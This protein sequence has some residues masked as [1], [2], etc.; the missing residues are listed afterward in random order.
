MTN[1]QPSVKT[2]FGSRFTR[3]ELAKGAA[4]GAAL[5]AAPHIARAQDSEVTLNFLWRSGTAYDG[6]LPV[7]AEFEAQHPGVKINIEDYPFRQMFEVVEIRMQARSPDIDIVAVDS[8]LTASYSVRG[9]LHPLNDFFTEE[10]LATSWVDAI[11]GAGT[12]NGQF[13]SAP[14]NNSSQ[15]LYL[16]LD[17]FAAQGVEP[18]PHLTYGV[19]AE[20]IEQVT[21]ARWTWDQ[22][23][24]AAQAL[25][26]D[27]D[28]DGRTDVWGFHFHQ[29]N[30]P[31][32]ILALPESLNQP[33]ISEDGLV[34]D[35]YLNSENWFR[36][37]GFYRDLFNDLAVS[38]KGVTSEESNELFASGGAAMYLGTVGQLPTFVG[39][40]GLN[41]GVAAHPYFADGRVATPTGSW[42]VGVSAFSEHKELAGEFV[43]FFTGSSEGNQLWYDNY[44]D[45]PAFQEL[46]GYI[47]TAEEFDEF[48]NNSYRLAAYESRN[49]AVPRPLTPGWLEFEDILSTTLEDIRNGD[50]PESALN[51]AVQR[52]DRSLER[53]QGV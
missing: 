13:M 51:V 45:F 5:F 40:E 20:A 9:F 16:N 2:R 39:R 6:V 32:Q 1:A 14:C 30:R 3:R 11:V 37:A 44:G 31:Y 7:V 18:P 42:H 53:F 49:T 29:V 52:I 23:A 24:E 21:G 46:L 15:L 50:D 47:E 35:G 27:T 28:G 12:W 22:L 17:H 43:H 48:T 34:T 41:F 19:G 10:E 33:S 8:P 26:V 25:T 4:A 38:P 36:A